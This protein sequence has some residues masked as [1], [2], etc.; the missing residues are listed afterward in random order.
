MAGLDLLVIAVDSEIDR[1]KTTVVSLTG[2]IKCVH[3][4]RISEWADIDNLIN[5]IFRAF[6]EFILIILKT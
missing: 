1:M 3:E 5:R 6:R 2:I 4:K